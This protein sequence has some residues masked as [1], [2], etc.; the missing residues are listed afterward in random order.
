MNYEELGFKCGLEIHQQIEGKKLFCNCKTINLRDTNPDIKFERYLRAV[1]GETGKI[2]MAASFEMKKSKKY[3]YE[4]DSK[5]CCLVEQDEEPP[6]SVNHEAL[7]VVLQI[8]KIMNAKIVD[9]IQFMRKTVVD[10]SN[11]SG[12]QRTTLIAYDGYI[13]TSKGNVIVESICLEEEA[14]QK[15]NDSK[16]FVRYR[17]DRLGIPLIEIATDASIKDNLHAKE[18]AEKIGMILRSTGKVKRGIGSIRQD[19]NLSIK[20]RNRVEIK[21]FQ[22]IKSISKVIENEINRQTKLIKKEDSHVRRISK[23]FKTEYL[24]PMPGASRMYPETDVS[25]LKID[26]IFVK[27]IK[28]VELISEKLEKFEKKYGINQDKIQAMMK[29]QINGESSFSVF[30]KILDKCKKI[31]PS[32]VC[33]TLL[34]YKN[35]IYN[36]HPNSNPTIISKD[37]FLLIFTELNNEKIAKNS[38]HNILI[39][40]SKDKKI[41]FS[42]YEIKD[43]D[44]TDDVKKIIEEKPGLSKDA[45]M[46]IIMKQFKGKVDGKKVMDVL[47]KLLK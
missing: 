34:S 41:D 19:V 1:A 16:D 18:V 4:G 32:F 42:K 24:R 47:N 31:K 12:F 2:D 10:G 14:A 17:L 35:E 44:I 29:N 21:G 36:N 7:N 9:E 46:G 40:I 37:N 23:D 45:Y 3:I 27:N 13:E 26:K 5:D 28:S 43:I 22:D 20:D 11:V 33:E 6:H 25:V 38:V 30:E 8:A 39:D 15:I